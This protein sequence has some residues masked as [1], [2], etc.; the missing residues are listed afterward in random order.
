MI[1]I[2][3]FL[4]AYAFYML[5]STSKRAE[6]TLTTKSQKYFHSHCKLTKYTACTLLILTLIICIYLWRV[7]GFFSWLAI[8][9]TMGCLI[10]LL[11]PMRLFSNNQII[12]FFLGM[13]LIELYFTY[14]SK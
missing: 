4:V 14:A 1:T 12:V 3:I 5:Y 11:F 8:L 6:L 2:L 9:M 10:V 13:L 7:S